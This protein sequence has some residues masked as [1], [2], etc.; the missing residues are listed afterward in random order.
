M[1]TTHTTRIAAA[2]ALSMAA[3][4]AM[5]KGP[6]VAPSQKAQIKASVERYTAGAVIVGNVYPTPIPGFFE[7][8]SGLDVFYVDGAGRYAMVEGRLVDLSTKQDLTQA[9]MEQVQRIDF[10]TL[11][12]DLAIKTVQ[13]N[14]RRVLA[15]FE[16]PTCAV[17]RSLHKFIAQ[18][19]DVT[20]YSFAYP[21]A[22]REALPI[23]KAAWCAPNRAAAWKLAMN[24][25]SKPEEAS[26]CDTSGIGRI[27]ALGE[28]LQVAGTPTVFLSNGRRMVGATPPDQFV[29][30]LDELAPRAAR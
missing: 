3:L 26:T 9:R 2:L 5:A 22:S 25:T 29:Q 7:V 8:T 21:I 19:P 1:I 27:L 10:S 18:L 20:V 12:L 14:G 24:G 13:G 15:V 17:C 4:H 6:E 16:D 11:P 30:A 28:A 23:A